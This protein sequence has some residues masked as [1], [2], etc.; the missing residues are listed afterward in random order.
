MENVV[1]GEWC[2]TPPIFLKKKN[3]E[4]S[5]IQ[6][7]KWDLYSLELSSRRDQRIFLYLSFHNGSL[8]SLFEK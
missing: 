7:R 2:V 5:E 1:Y 8:G 3:G 6:S 4:G